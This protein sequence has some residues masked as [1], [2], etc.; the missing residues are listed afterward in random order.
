MLEDRKSLEAVIRLN[1]IEKKGEKY[2]I[3]FSQSS[4]NYY[5]L[6]SDSICARWKAGDLFWM[7]GDLIPISG[8]SRPDQ[9]NFKAYLQNQN[10]IARLHWKRIAKI[11][12]EATFKDLLVNY[13]NSLAQRI[14]SWPWAE[15][16]K[17]L[18]KALF[19]G[20][21]GDLDSEMRQDF[22]AAG[23]MHVLAVSGL[24]LG[25]I[26]LLLQFLLKPLKALPY[27]RILNCILSIIGIWAFSF[28]SGAGPSVL[29]A[30]T[31]FSFLAIGKAINRPGSGLSS[32][33][34]SALV[35][36]WFQPLLIRQLGFLL[37]YS[38][39][40]GILFLVPKMKAWHSFKFQPLKSVQELIYVSIAAQL[41]TA[42]ISL[43][44]FGSFPLY[45]LL[46]N[47]LVL[48][49]MSLIMY[50]GL[51]VLLLDPFP[52]FSFF[53][54]SF[55]IA[56]EYMSKI[57]A[58]ISSFPN[59]QIQWNISWFNCTLSYI[60]LAYWL[61][62]SRLSLKKFIALIM[63]LGIISYGQSLYQKMVTAQS[64]VIYSG[65]DR[66]LVY[67]TG[68][69]E[70]HLN[71]GEVKTSQ[72][73]LS[74]LPYIDQ[75]LNI[76]EEKDQIILT[77]PLSVNSLILVNDQTQMEVKDSALVVYTGFSLEK[78]KAW[79]SYCQ[80]LNISF[81]SCRKGYLTIP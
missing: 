3:H 66:E 31:L 72:R 7:D 12:S 28:L 5:C 13:R 38:A 6:S 45:F 44:T 61:I 34:A 64:L 58:W 40:I 43:N 79:Q 8:P 73:K 74:S 25:M 63:C 1:Y 48:P 30:A 17:A 77:S 53:R 67:R 9:F 22:G 80:A 29:R 50:A 54:D 46:A 27:F 14:D 69:T 26:Y 37:S 33:W 60:L 49:L 51:L 11:K 52:I 18:Y 55:P 21:K 59:A 81:R 65:N 41:F 70:Y 78:E 15:K 19:L 4:E 35:L 10:L 23:L 42:P 76:K 56:L 62:H 20:L 39:V 32:V 71:A 36:L 75:N 47:L 24:H 2:Q 57:S 68:S 16:H